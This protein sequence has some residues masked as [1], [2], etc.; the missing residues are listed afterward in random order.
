MTLV[1]FVDNIVWP[2]AKIF[3]Y[4]WHV[5]KNWAENAIK[6]I[7]EVTKRATVLQMLGDIMYGK[8]CFVWDDPVT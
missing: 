4:L 2:E 5:R 3:L 8:G 6:K 1:F 7:P